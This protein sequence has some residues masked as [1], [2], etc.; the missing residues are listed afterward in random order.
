MKELSGRCGEN[1]EVLVAIGIRG[2][3]SCLEYALTEGL[4]ETLAEYRPIFTL[5]DGREIYYFFLACEC[6]LS[7]VCIH[8]HVPTTHKL[9]LTHWSF[10]LEQL[11]PL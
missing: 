8:L 7:Y 2:I 10:L 1:M 9:N 3:N 6:C 4:V 5:L 11:H